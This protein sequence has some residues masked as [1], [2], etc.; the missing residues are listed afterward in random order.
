MIKLN[1]NSL[2]TT[3]LIDLI[4]Q[5]NSGVTELVILCSEYLDQSVETQ[6]WLLDKVNNYLSFI[7]SNEYKEEF[8]ALS[9]NKTFIIFKCHKVHKIISQLIGD[10]EQK[11]LPYNVIIKVE[12]V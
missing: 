7:M 8:G 4:I 11:L 10:I 1:K 2:S 12:F 6:Q 5:K 9:I 3:D